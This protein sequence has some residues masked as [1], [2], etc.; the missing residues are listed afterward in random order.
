MPMIDR[1]KSARGSMAVYVTIVILSMLLVLLALFFTSNAIRKNQL[2]TALKVKEAYEADNKNAGKIYQG[3][4]KGSVPDSVEDAKPAQDEEVYKF[5][6]TTQIEDASGD[7]IWIPGGFGI[8]SDSATEIDDGVVIT[9]GTNEFVWIPVSDTDLAEMYST[10]TPET[11]VS[12]TLSQSA[13]REAATTTNIYSKLRAA[14]SYVGVAPGNTSYR[15]PE[16][17]SN[18]TYGDASTASSR[19]IDLLISELGYSG[20]SAQILKNFAQDM[21]DEY[22][23]VFNS[24]KSYDGF[25]IGRYELTGT[26]SKPTVQKNQPVLTLYLGLINMHKV[27]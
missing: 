14:N 17:L 10:T 26:A 9:D 18:A 12:V 5:P 25:Y 15:E 11:A 22:L 27:I 4:T 1:L 6:E 23:A 2:V 13:L 21:V 20:A 16:I 19:G 7:K 8:T 24:I 3:L